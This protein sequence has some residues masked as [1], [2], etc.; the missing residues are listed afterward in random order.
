MIEKIRKNKKGASSIETAVIFLV[1]MIVFSVVLEY[2]SLNTIMKTT[3]DDAQRVLDSTV[4]KNAMT[5]F[6]S[7]K[8]GRSS[9][10]STQYDYDKVLD[11]LGLNPKDFTE[12]LVGEEGMSLEN[13]NGKYYRTG[14]GDDEVFIVPPESFT[15]DT[16][17]ADQ[18]YITADFIVGRTIYF[19]GH[20][21]F[22]VS[23]K[24]GLDTMYTRK[25]AISSGQ[26]P[27]TEVE[28]T[29]SL[30]HRNG[31]QVREVVIPNITLDGDVYT[32]QAPKSPGGIV[33]N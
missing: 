6:T 7:I 31:D 5:V 16:A 23:V 18:L 11:Q 19:M 4:V 13:K 12:R 29:G 28:Q 22:N 15:V 20:E 9:V 27:P 14:S 25:N 21:V 2:A 3:R 1:I 24:M 26:E 33:I 17:T 32:T 8:N 10:L 30:L